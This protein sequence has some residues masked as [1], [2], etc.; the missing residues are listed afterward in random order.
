VSKRKIES[1]AA[2]NMQQISPALP[3]ELVAELDRIATS[4]GTTRQT[5]V[6]WAVRDYVKKYPKFAQLRDMVS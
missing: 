4:E 6:L 3:K 5:I 1:L 2:R